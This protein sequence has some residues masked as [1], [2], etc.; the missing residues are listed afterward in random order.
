MQSSNH[1]TYLILGAGPAG[2]QLGYYFA[3]TGEDYR[4]LEAGDG[5]GTFFATF[6]R[7]RTLISINKVNTGLDDPEENLRYDWNSLLCDR[8]ELSFTRYSKAYFPPAEDFLRYLQDFTQAY[9]LR[10]Q[11]GCRIERVARNGCF[12][13]TDQH[14]QVYTCDRLIVATGVSL[15]YEAKIPGIELAENYV[16][17]PL[18]PAGF[19]NQRVLI[20]GKGN[21]AFETADALMEAAAVIHLAS[22]EP[23]K[24]AWQTHFVGNLRAVNNNFL[25]TYQL[26]SQNAVIDA[27]IESIQRREDGKLVVDIQFTHARG[28]RRRILYDRVLA[29]TGFRFDTSIFDQDCRP[30]LCPRGKL[31]QMTSEWQ[32]VNVPDLYFAGTLMQMRD[33]KKTMSGFVH[34]FRHNVLALHRL[35]ASKYHGR[36]WPCQRL[37]LVPEAVVEAVLDRINRSSGLFL[38]PGFLADLVVLDPEREEACYYPELPVDYLKDHAFNGA[39]HYY[40]V[41]LEYGRF[42]TDFLSTERN[43][44]PMA[45]HTASYLHPVIRR[46]HRGEQVGE[47]HIHDD[48]ENEWHTPELVQPFAAFVTQD[49]SQLQPEAVRS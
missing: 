23:V 36:S 35:L 21:S 10:V 3:Q 20:L 45:A 16:D 40:M 43:P 15:P 28:Q 30:P 17:M 25:D 42:D 32:A 34:G 2:L 48:L 6:P 11:Y 4:I 31:P 49:L 5:P 41:T 7:H 9:D 44:D 47:Q 24:L 26:K 18:D 37:P 12:Q 29:C 27:E 33:Y 38:Q 8:P 39:E 46:Y 1:H 19:V 14:G 22:P 13:L